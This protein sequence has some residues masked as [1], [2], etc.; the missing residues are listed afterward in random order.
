MR[1]EEKIEE[2]RRGGEERGAEDRRKGEVKKRDRTG[3]R[4][5]GDETRR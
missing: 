1:G 5:T 2:R 3:E 4:K